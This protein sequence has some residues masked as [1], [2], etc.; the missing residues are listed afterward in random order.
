LSF[1]VWKTQVASCIPA[2]LLEKQTAFGILLSKRHWT[3]E[4]WIQ[5]ELTESFLK[6]LGPKYKI[7]ITETA[8]VV[9]SKV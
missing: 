9:T 6:L 4:I 3:K 2:C 7:E 1:P 8:I 5:N